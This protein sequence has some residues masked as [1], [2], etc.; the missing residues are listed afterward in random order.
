MPSSEDETTPPA[1]FG[2]VLHVDPSVLDVTPM[3]ERFGQVYRYPIGDGDRARAMAPG[4]PCFLL[5]TDR[6]KVIGIWAIG[7][8]VAPCVA[9]AVDD[10]HPAAGRAEPLDEDGDQLYA[11]VDL[12]PLEKPLALTK[13][14][15]AKALAASELAA[16][17]D[18]VN[19]LLLT[20]AQ[21]RAIETFDFW[22]TEPSDD[23]RRALDEVL[24]AEEIE[25]IDADAG[26]MGSVPTN[27]NEPSPA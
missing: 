5:R 18:G 13:L 10:D 22:L 26:A 17:P 1:G 3:I 6:S 8:V 7:E 24:D 12:V 27:P 23:Q 4:Q 25:E 2:W 11:E 9:I 16:P 21:V 14:L 20:R 19:P 15:E